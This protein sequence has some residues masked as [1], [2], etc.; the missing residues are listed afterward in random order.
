MKLLQLVYGFISTATLAT[1]TL[2]MT[3]KVDVFGL[4]DY[5]CTG[6]C[7]VDTD[8]Y[9]YCK[10]ECYDP[11]PDTESIPWPVEGSIVFSVGQKF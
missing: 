7:A 8:C 4:S 5:E 11:N 1:S 6:T 10:G 2:T 3:S 9:G